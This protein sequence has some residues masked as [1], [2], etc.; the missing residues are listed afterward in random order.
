MKIL[1]RFLEWLNSPP[2][3]SEDVQDAEYTVIVNADPRVHRISVNPVWVRR[4]TKDKKE[5]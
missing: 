4:N 2:V 5:A 3:M 1:S